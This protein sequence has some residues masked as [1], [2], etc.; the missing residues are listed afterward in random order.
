[1]AFFKDRHDATIIAVHAPGGPIAVNARSETVVKRGDCLF[2]LAAER[3]KPDDIDW[4]ACA[5]H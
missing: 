4:V 1:M 5:N 3:L 2:L